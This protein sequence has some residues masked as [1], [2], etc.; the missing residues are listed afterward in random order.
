MLVNPMHT[1]S[2]KVERYSY[3]PF[4]RRRSADNWLQDAKTEPRFARGY[5]IPSLISAS[6]SNNHKNK[7]YEIEASYY[8]KRH[9]TEK[10]GNDI[11]TN[12]IE[13]KHPTK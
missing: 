5:C 2:G 10:Y 13:E 9:F 7:W 1:A 4:G 6:Q 11:W 12:S 3:D 8:G